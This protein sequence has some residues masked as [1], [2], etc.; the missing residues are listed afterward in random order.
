MMHSVYTNSYLKLAATHAS[1]SSKGLF[2]KR[3][4]PSHHREKPIKHSVAHFHTFEF[5]LLADSLSTIS[6][7][8]GRHLAPGG[9]KSYKIYVRYSL[10]VVH[11]DVTTFDNVIFNR[12][13]TLKRC[14][15]LLTRARAFQERILAPR[16]VHFHSSELTWDCGEGFD[17]ECGEL[18]CTSST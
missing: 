16:T 3:F 17:C 1:N 12:A 5:P 2:S 14:A 7:Q 6:Q 10:E 15:P 8:H 4:V 13:D 18:A 9:D 11:T